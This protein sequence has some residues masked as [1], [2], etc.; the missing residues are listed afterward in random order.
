[1]KIVGIDVDALAV[2]RAELQAELTTI[3]NVLNLVNREVVTVTPIEPEPVAPIPI[4]AN[5]PIRTYNQGLRR[6]VVLA[7]MTGPTKIEDLA[8]FQNWETRKVA[9]ILNSSVRAKVVT[10]KD[11]LWAL[12]THGIQ[13]AKWF[14]GHPQCIVYRPGDVVETGVRS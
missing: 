12:T 9:T 11:G 14:Q 8:R 6:K 13:T 1:M 7:L 10:E 2:R 3:E 4:K 5:R